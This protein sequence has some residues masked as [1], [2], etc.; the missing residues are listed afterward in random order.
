MYLP[1]T[2]PR[3]V[4][5]LDPDFSPAV[6]W[7]RAYRAS[8]Q[9][10]VPLVLALEGEQGR[11]SRYETVV[12]AVVDEETLRYAERLVKFLLWSR[13]GWRLIVGGPRE[14]ADCIA[15]AYSQD[16]ARAFDAGMMEKSYGRAFVVEG[17]AAH[18]VPEAKEA[19]AAI[20]GHLD[21]CRHDGPFRAGGIRALGAHRACCGREDRVTPAV[22]PATR[23]GSETFSP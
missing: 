1:A 10:G 9:D 15:L 4:P 7:N 11:I 16:G 8:V 19:S 17:A 3:R 21:G 12:R 6:L 20:G 18:T 23:Y 22:W 14:I 13:G 2:K 5:E